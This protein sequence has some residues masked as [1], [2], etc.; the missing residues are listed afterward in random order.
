MK[1]LIRRFAAFVTV[2]ALVFAQLAVS[3]FACPDDASQRAHALVNSTSGDCEKL[4]N[5]NLCE[6]HCDYGSS[7]VHTLSAASPAPDL[8][9]LPWRVQALQLSA[10]RSSVRARLAPR[11]IDPP[12]LILF[13]VLRI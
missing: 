5:P 4:S 8:A 3:A 10:A 12:P 11:R 7:S 13:G 6:Q 9:P 1:R 2:A